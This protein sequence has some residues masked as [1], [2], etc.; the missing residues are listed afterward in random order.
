MGL[1]ALGLVGAFLGVASLQPPRDLKLHD[2]PISIVVLASDPAGELDR[3]RAE[4][5]VGILNDRFIDDLG[6]RI[7]AFHL[8]RF[9]VAD[10]TM[11]CEELRALGDQK[12]KADRSDV[13]SA[14][15]RC[16]DPRLVDRSAISMFLFRSSWDDGPD[17]KSS[18]VYSPVFE[19]FVFIN[20]DRLDDDWAVLEHEMAHAFGLPESTACGSTPST[21]SNPMGHTMDFCEG[22]GGNRLL[23]FANWQAA[24]MRTTAPLVLR[25]LK[26]KTN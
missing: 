2:V 7:F 9:S 15:E 19:P 24:I 14:F 13:L 23:P 25:S 3:P 22:T 8:T 26:A 4:R 20:V 16:P 1:K 10:E 11:P 5:L 12:V 21:P 17:R 6:R 18:Y